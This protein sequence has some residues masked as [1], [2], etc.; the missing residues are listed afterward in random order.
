M[1]CIGTDTSA[2]VAVVAGGDGAGSGIG[3]M[4]HRKRRARRI[5]PPLRGQMGHHLRTCLSCT[6]PELPLPF[7]L[8]LGLKTQVPTVERREEEGYARVQYDEQVKGKGILWL[9]R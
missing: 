8:K 2:A 3:T 6:P 1:D 4:K 9:F 7:L 5:L